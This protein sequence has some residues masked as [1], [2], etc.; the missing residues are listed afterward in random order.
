MTDE[1]FNRPRTD[2]R[3]IRPNY[4]RTMGIPLLRGRDFTDHDAG[5]DR[6]VFII[7]QS[8]AAKYWANVEPIGSQIMR[9]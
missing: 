5:P 6:P 4:F 1:E 2:V 3:S 9:C 8:P 7:N